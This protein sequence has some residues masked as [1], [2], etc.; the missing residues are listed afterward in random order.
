MSLW[1]SYVLCKIEKI[2]STKNK[3]EKEKFF[4]AKY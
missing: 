1:V 2:L 4:I 3:K